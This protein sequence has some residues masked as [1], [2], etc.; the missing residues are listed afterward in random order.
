MTMPDVG[1]VLAL[2]FIKKLCN[3][4]THPRKVREAALRTLP[5]GSSPHAD[6]CR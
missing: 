3:D 5:R 6:F 4:R 1:M 2:S